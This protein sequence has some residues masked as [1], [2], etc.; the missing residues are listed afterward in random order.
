VSGYLISDGK[1]GFTKDYKVMKI[2]DGEAV[3]ISR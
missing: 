3:E 2:V 1:G